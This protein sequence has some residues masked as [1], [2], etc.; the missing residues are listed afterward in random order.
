M[1]NL[2]NRY[3]AS[4]AVRLHEKYVIKSED[5]GSSGTFEL[6]LPNKGI[7]TPDG[8]SLE[9]W[10][11]RENTAMRLFNFEE[12]NSR[13]VS[14]NLEDVPLKEGETL[15]FLEYYGYVD[16][17]TGNTQRIMDLE[18]YRFD[19]RIISSSTTLEL[20]SLNTQITVPLEDENDI[21]I[22]LPLASEQVGSSLS[23]LKSGAGQGRVIL[24]SQGSNVI[25]HL[26]WQQNFWDILYQGEG[27][28]LYSDGSRWVIESLL[29][30]DLF[31]G[32]FFWHFSKEAPL[33]ATICDGSEL[34]KDKYRRLFY[35]YGL[36]SNISLPFSEGDSS[37][38][39]KLPDMRGQFL[40]GYDDTA[41]VDA[42]NR[43]FGELQKDQFQGHWHELYLR[44]HSADSYN[45]TRYNGGSVPTAEADTHM[46]ADN[47]VRYALSDNENGDPRIGDETRPKNIALLPCMVL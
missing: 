5:A 2:K 27:I 20:D 10:L 39:F 25:Y 7:Y 36:D 29:G 35:R 3:P 19:K 4:S 45:Y 24:S 8:K 11:E 44:A 21:T 31:P 38:A 13:T 42:S 22:T 34:D 47:F 32:D 37:D 1:R 14:L 41:L 12:I 17:D 6:E 40:R 15:R 23:I 28:K 16:N 30:L 18:R 46:T 43:V 33:F 9:I 26:K